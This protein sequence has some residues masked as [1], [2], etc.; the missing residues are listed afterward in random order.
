MASRI[1]WTDRQ[2][3]DPLSLQRLETC[4]RLSGLCFDSGQCA[5]RYADPLHC[6]SESKMC[7]DVANRFEQTWPP[8]KSC[9]SL[10]TRRWS[11]GL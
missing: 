10:A 6:T 4:F 11:F 5:F 3:P 2:P 9:I 7:M 8:S 1:G